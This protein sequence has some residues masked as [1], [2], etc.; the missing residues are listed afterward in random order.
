MVP[1][2]VETV[3][4]SRPAIS[5][6]PVQNSS[7]RDTLDLC[8][9]RM[10]ERLITD[11]L[12]CMP[13]PRYGYCHLVA[14]GSRRIGSCRRVLVISARSSY[15]SLSPGVLNRS[16]KLTDRLTYE[17]EPKNGLNPGKKGRNSKGLP[18]NLNR[19]VSRGQSVP[20]DAK[21]RTGPWS[22]FTPGGHR[23]R[24]LGTGRGDSP[25]ASHEAD[26]K[27]PF[28]NCQV[29]PTNG[30]CRLTVVQ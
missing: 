23:A 19:N 6:N 21:N 7:S 8:P 4:F 13:S 25:R 5:R 12:T 27:W 18:V 20:L 15:I 14:S 2:N 22:H 29:V 26:S 1:T 28:W 17:L 3:I 24:R 16:H 30:A 9:S 11:E 10:I